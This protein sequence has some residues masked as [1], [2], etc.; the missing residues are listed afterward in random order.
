[1]KKYILIMLLVILYFTAIAGY[2]EGEKKGAYIG[3]KSGA[4]N[5]DKVNSLN[6]FSLGGTAGYTIPFRIRHI[7]VALE[8]DFNLGYFGGDYV[9]GY[10]G[11]R[12]HIRTLGL[13]GVVRTI[14]VNEIYAKGKIGITAET[15]IEK[16]GNMESLYKEE[17]LSC[18]IGVGYMASNHVNVEGELTTTNSD[19]KFF[20]IV[21]AFVF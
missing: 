2:A 7:E 3:L 14:P 1:M 21:L 19:M 20:S 5:L 9:S 6:I 13:Y 12:S 11:D 4:F 17:G 16:I 8:W 15:V 18:G 10:P